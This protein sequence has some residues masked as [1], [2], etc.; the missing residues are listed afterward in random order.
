MDNLSIDIEIEN[1]QASFL[2]G[3]VLSGSV[4]WL[5]SELPNNAS[6]HLIWY[7]EGKGDEDVGLVEKSEFE[8]PRMS[9]ERQFEFRLPAGPYSFSGKLI[10]LIWALELQVGKEVIRK[11]IVLSPSGEEINLCKQEQP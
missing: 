4:R 11:E 2:P 5:C 6:A 3:G 1:N 10:S 8:N 7:T 9:D